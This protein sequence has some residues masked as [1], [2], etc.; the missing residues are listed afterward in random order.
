MQRR[1]ANPG[2]TLL[3]L[4]ALLLPTAALADATLI[5]RWVLNEELTAEVA[6]KQSRRTSAAGG[7]RATVS[8]GGMPLPGTSTALP[9]V[10]G[11]ARDPGVLRCSVLTIESRGDNLHLDYQGVGSDTLK[12]GNDQGLVSRWGAR[13]LTTGYET[14]SRKVSQTYQVQRDGR[15]LVTVKL[16]PNTGPTVVHKRV[17]DPV[18]AQ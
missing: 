4:A 14:T 1:Q 6:P 2:I 15:L 18:T 9:Q 8:V 11:T 7:P 17:F 3:A 10:A 13:K 5:G 16:N 12:R